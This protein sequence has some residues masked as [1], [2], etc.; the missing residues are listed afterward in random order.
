LHCILLSGYSPPASF[1]IQL[2]RNYSAPDCDKFFVFFIHLSFF[3]GVVL[4]RGVLP[5]EMLVHHNSEQAML[6][7]RVV[8]SF[9]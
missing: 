8:E 3:C 2:Q 5:K 4:S 9:I 7:L 6:R 1:N